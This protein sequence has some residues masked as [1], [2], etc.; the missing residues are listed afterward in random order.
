MQ[1]QHARDLVTY[2]NSWV[3]WVLLYVHG[4]CT[5][6]TDG[7]PGWPPRLSHSS[8]ALSVTL[9]WHAN[10]YKVPCIYSHVPCI[11]CPNVPCIYSHV[12]WVTEGDSS[13]PRVY[14]SCISCIPGENYRRQLR[15]L[16]SYLCVI[17]Q[18]LINSLVCWINN[19]VVKN[20]WQTDTAPLRSQ[21]CHHHLKGSCP[22]HCLHHARPSHLSQGS[23][24]AVTASVAT[25]DHDDVL[26]LGRD[27]GAVVAVLLLLPGLQ[28]VHGIVDA[29]Q[30]TAWKEENND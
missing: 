23:G 4:N 29:F 30:L 5:L 15:S 26:V 3:G 13:Y 12:R 2:S 19:T 27:V 9:T 14:V 7:S 25:A 22:R 20:H 24:D 8:W 18:I 17:F 1:D 16:L 6:I 21:G 11:P 28:E 10:K